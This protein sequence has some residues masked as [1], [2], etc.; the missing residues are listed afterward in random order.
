MILSILALDYGQSSLLVSSLYVQQNLAFLLSLSSIIHLY[1]LALNRCK[2]SGNDIYSTAKMDCTIAISIF[3]GRSQ[4][5]IT[6]MLGYFYSCYAEFILGNI[7]LDEWKG[8]AYNLMIK[9]QDKAIKCFMFSKHIIILMI[10]FSCN[11][12]SPY[13]NRHFCNLCQCYVTARGKCNIN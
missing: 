2:H 10:L 1:A 6:E 8:M 13:F 5:N 12:C 3:G 4:I 7:S 11:P 9:N